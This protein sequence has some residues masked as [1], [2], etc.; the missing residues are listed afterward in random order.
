MQSLS[1][2]QIDDIRMRMGNIYQLK[3]FLKE[4]HQIIG[5]IESLLKS[6]Q[7]KTKLSKLI[8]KLQVILNENSVKIVEFFVKK[9]K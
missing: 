4:E 6:S 3:D 7:I 9:I 5:W 1:E 2:E 8:Q